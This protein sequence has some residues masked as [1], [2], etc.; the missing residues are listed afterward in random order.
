MSNWSKYPDLE[1]IRRLKEEG[2]ELLGKVVLFTEKRDGENVSIWLG[3]D[4]NPQISSHHQET[5]DNNIQSRMMAT[6]EY[7]RAVDLLREECKYGKS[8]ILYGE[9]LKTV[10]PTRIEPKRK[11]VHWVLFDM[12]DVVTGEFAHYSYVYQLGFNFRIPIVGAVGEIRVESLELLD[13]S[14]I[15]AL[16]WCRKH[17]RE[18]I[19]GKCHE[20]QIFFKEKVNLPKRS[21]IPRA[22]GKPMLPEMDQRTILRALQH[23]YDEVIKLGHDWMDRSKAMPIVAR[24]FSA[25]ASEHYFSAP[26]NMYQLYIDAK[27][28]DLKGVIKNE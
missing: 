14:I 13:A 17:K 26:K 15:G 28:D 27:I 9:L 7:E 6:P 20:E 8:W 3:S 11:H 12:R 18:G 19:V 4:N 10:S 22:M 21:K 5:A 23:A 24:H 16:K 25:E 1:P 2:R